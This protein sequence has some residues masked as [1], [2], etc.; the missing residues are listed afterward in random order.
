MRDD[1]RLLL[2]LVDPTSLLTPERAGALV[3]EATPAAIESLLKLAAGH[4]VEG[5]LGARLNAISADS[6]PADLRDPLIR[7]L[8]RNK[9]RAMS[10]LRERDRILHA[11][12]QHDISCIVL[13]GADLAYR[14]YSDPGARPFEDLDLLVHEADVSKADNALRDLDYATPPD[15]LPFPLIRKLHFHLPY[16]HRDGRAFV[17][18]HWQ[19]VDSHTM[20]PKTLD[21]AWA[22]SE[23][24]PEGWR[25]LSP[26]TYAAYLA[27]HLAKHGVLNP[28][29][30]THVRAVE[31]LLHPWADAR[32]IW[33][34]DLWQLAERFALLP[35]DILDAGE[36]LGC[37]V[38]VDQALRFV[39]KLFP[40]CPWT[41]P[42]ASP[43]EK[44]GRVSQTV[45]N[46]LLRRILEDLNHDQLAEGDSPWLLT[47][48]KRL[49]IRPI[50]MFSRRR[51]NV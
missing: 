40:D 17:E 36:K 28:Q 3:A 25:V 30:A 35:K 21:G 34:I 51:A 42:P 10:A 41:L 47:T 8:H 23:H 33:F 7:A 27:V 2:G 38:E 1:V 44:L 19:L 46:R 13:K 15:L 20:N 37:R 16:L 14:I 45:T 11:F 50:R 48:N 29:I 49:H 43:A 39:Q 26:A 4:R 18:V 24:C 31:I 22:G 32:L 12:A 9:V 6:V 5:F